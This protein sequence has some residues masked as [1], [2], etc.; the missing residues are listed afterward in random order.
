ME[1]DG[2]AI[3]LVPTG[4]FA[5]QG[6]FPMNAG[7]AAHAWEADQRIEQLTGQVF[8]QDYRSN[9]LQS[10]KGGVDSGPATLAL[11]AVRLTAPKREFEALKAIQSAR[12]VDGR[13][14]ADQ[15]II[16]DVLAKLN[17]NEAATRFVTPDE[18]LLSVNRARI[19]EGQVELRR[20][21]VRGVPTLI[22][23]QGQDRRVVSSSAFYG[24]ADT[25]I[26]DLRAAWKSHLTSEKEQTMYTRREIM[27][28][29]LASGVAMAASSRLALAA[30]LLSWKHF[31]TDDNG[32]LRAPVLVTGPTEAVLID[33]GFTLSDG[34]TV[35]EAIKASGKKLTTVYVSVNDPDYYF[36]LGP[37]KDAFPEARIIAAPD[38]VEAIKGNVEKK[39]EAWGPKLGDNGP[40]SLEQVVMP[41]PSD[42]TSIAVDGETIEIVAIDGMH[43]RRYHW[44]TSLEAVFGGVLAYGGLHPWI[45][46]VP[47]PEDRAAWIRALDSIAARKPK[48]VVP[49]HMKPDWPTDLS[50]VTFTRDYLV[51]YE[52]EFAKAEDSGELIAAMKKRYPDAGLHVALEIGAKVAKGE[53]KWG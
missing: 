18:E 2:F 45:A 34:R 43:D 17:L 27:K 20:F 3:E 9:V 38:T 33:G 39:L 8:T 22:A 4:L 51:A 42:V 15:A 24:N 16:A 44:V 19:A 13:D 46:D 1:Q 21:G 50:G 6:A 37:V 52:E 35:A 40:G 23:G 14:N 11:T 41:E 5:D 7:F 49:G 47:K 32:F 36:S 25:L 12:Y 10:G 48:I 30:S 28:T 26:A 31:P 29:T 53:M